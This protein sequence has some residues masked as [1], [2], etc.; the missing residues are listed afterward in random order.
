[1]GRPDQAEA[2]K[3]YDQIISAASDLFIENGFSTT[4]MADIAAKARVSKQTVYRHF[5]TKNGI[6]A[7]AFNYEAD[8]LRESF[9]ITAGQSSLAPEQALK[10][11]CKGAIL[12]TLRPRAIKL[13]RIAIVEMHRFPHLVDLLRE[14]SIAH[15]IEPLTRHVRRGQD[16]GIFRQ[17]DPDILGQQL[18]MASNG[19]AFLLTLFGSD[20]FEDIDH[21]AAYFETVWPTAIAGI[22]HT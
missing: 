5:Q 1:M 19:M 16:M 21:C 14:Q 3:I 18:F 2:R 9:A 11:L 7:A 6:F 20:M 22:T 10:S 4:T 12:G 8:R 15:I 17:G 13:T